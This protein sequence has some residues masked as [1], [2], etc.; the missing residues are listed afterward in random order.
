[1]M[2]RDRDNERERASIH[3]QE[4]KEKLGEVGTT[5][6]QAKSQGTFYTGDRERWREVR[7]TTRK[8]YGETRREPNKGRED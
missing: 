8:D 7:L 3:A 1:M 6:R 5:E 2:M 4:S